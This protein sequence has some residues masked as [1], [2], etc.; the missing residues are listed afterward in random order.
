MIESTR[1]IDEYNSLHLIYSNGEDTISL[2]EQ[3]SNDKRGLSSQDFR[4]YA[5]YSNIESDNDSGRQGQ[6]FFA[7]KNSALSF[8]LVGKISISRM[9]DIVQSINGGKD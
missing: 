8:V 9:L 7:W 3:P 5:V 4:D 2:F 6:T 1:K